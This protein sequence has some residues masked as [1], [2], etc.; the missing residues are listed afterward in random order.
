VVETVENWH[1]PLSPSKSPFINTIVSLLQVTAAQERLSDGRRQGLRPSSQ[2]NSQIQQRLA[3]PDV[4]RAEIRAD[5][6]VVIPLPPYDGVEMIVHRP[7]GEVEDHIWC[8]VSDRA[9]LAIYRPDGLLISFSCRHL[10]A[11]DLCTFGQ[12]RHKPCV[13]Q[14]T[15]SSSKQAGHTERV[16][17]ASQF[18]LFV[19]FIA[20]PAW[21]FGLPPLAASGGSWELQQFYSDAVRTNLYFGVFTGL[22]T[23]AIFLFA[24]VAWAAE[25]HVASRKTRNRIVNSN[26][27]LALLLLPCLPLLLLFL[28]KPYSADAV[29]SDSPMG[30]Y[31]LFS[32]VASFAFVG[33]IGAL[34]RRVREREEERGRAG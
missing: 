14:G 30:T 21:L 3:P 31:F 29:P 1:N 20:A 23:A 7:N 10:G 4:E 17:R 9:A 27:L 15:G 16:A 18:L 2:L 13:F 33:I 6:T 19:I 32:W 22:H 8:S 25:R 28:G 12:T 24:R 26:G 34:A 5:G 11:G